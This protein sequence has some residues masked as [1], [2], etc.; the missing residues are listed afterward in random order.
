[1]LAYEWIS[2]SGAFGQTYQVPIG[3]TV[4]PLGIGKCLRE[5]R[6]AKARNSSSLMSFNFLL[7]IGSDLNLDCEECSRGYRRARSRLHSHSC[8]C[9]DSLEDFF[10]C[11]KQAV[12]LGRL[13]SDKLAF[14]HFEITLFIVAATAAGNWTGMHEYLA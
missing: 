9:A 14:D 13:S 8:S 5:I 12:L 6:L 2:F 3:R 1:M 7:R 10:S 11:G 4:E